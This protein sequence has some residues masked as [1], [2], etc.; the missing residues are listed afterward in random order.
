[1]KIAIDAR[2]ISWYRGTGIGTYTNN[3]VNS[4]LKIDKENV[5]NL[6]WSGDN[7]NNFK[8][9]NSKIIMTS[10]KH[11]R[12]FEQYYF[13]YN[14]DY[15][16][17]DI[18]HVPQNGIG[19]NSYIHC[20]RVVTIHDLIPFLMP[21][22]VGRGYL[23]KF[24]KQMPSIIERSDAIITVSEWSKKDILR[25]FPIDPNKI[26]VTP[27][28]TDLK[29]RVL[30][31]TKCKNVIYKKY[32]INSPFILYIGGFS[33]R[34]NVKMLV[35]AFKETCKD[36]PIDYKL[37]IVGSYKNEGNEVLKLVEDLNLSSN[38]IFTGFVD[39][40]DLP[41]FYN[42]CNLFVYPSL[43]EGF[44]LP[45]LEAISCGAPTIASN[46]T[47]I[48]EVLENCGVLIN[49]NKISELRDSIGKVLTNNKLRDEMIQNGLKRSK[50]FSWDKTA[51]ATLN[52]YY[53]LKNK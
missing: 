47:S 23:L 38:V 13:P 1:M 35:K 22:T 50:E 31:K 4:L 26:Y 5:Y 28:A 36:L 34:K 24:L 17:V 43:Y 10:N 48:P 12:F 21:D 53:S 11:H 32:N 14:L 42:A 2:G 44:G 9:N 6:Y 40:I 25:F 29:Y 45:P 37:V 41:L 33:P 49:P 18:Y 20:K 27:L 51:N 39:E 46:T 30:N 15:E 7:F 19:L 3:L 52:V 16:K 8:K